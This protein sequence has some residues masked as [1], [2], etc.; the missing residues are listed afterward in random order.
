M[1]RVAGSLATGT[2]RAYD[3]MRMLSWDGHPSRLGQAFAE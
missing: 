2:V 1:L 3:L